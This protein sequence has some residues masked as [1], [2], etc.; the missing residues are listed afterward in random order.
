MDV[1]IKIQQHPDHYS[2]EKRRESEIFY[3]FEAGYANKYLKTKEQKEEDFQ[4]SFK[5]YF[6]S[7]GRQNREYNSY[8]ATDHYDS[9]FTMNSKYIFFQNSIGISYFN[10]KDRFCEENLKHI[11]FLACDHVVAEN[12]ESQIKEILVGSNPELV[13]IVL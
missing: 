3:I 10:L 7:I 2:E 13:V 5:A 8:V 4:T 9:K 6:D 11:D 1:C 12:G